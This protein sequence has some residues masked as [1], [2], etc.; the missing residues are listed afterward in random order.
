MWTSTRTSAPDKE[1]PQPQAGLS[2][3]GA[4]AAGEVLAGRFELTRRLGAGGLAEVFAA[5]DRLTGAEVAVKILH[6]H[7]ALDR[8]LAERFR[9][10]L[11]ITRGLDHPGIVRVFDLHEH[12]GRPLFSMELL[13]GR[14]LDEVLRD[15]GPMPS[16]A[17]RHLAKEICAALQAAHAAGVVHRD[18]KPQNVFVTSVGALKLLDFG[19][20]RVAGQTPLTSSMS[21]L[22]TPGYIA[23]ELLAGERADA[24]AD[25]YA[26]G[27][28]LCEMLTRRPPLASSDPYGAPSA[29]PRFDDLCAE[30]S[31]LLQRAL[32][33][34]PERRFL[35]AAQLMR[36]LSGEPVPRPL[37]AP[38][39][40]SAG[41]FDVLVHDVV[42]PLLVMRPLLLL[43]PRH[44]ASAA[45]ERAPL[46]SVLDR[47]GAE[48]STPWRLRLLGAGQA[49]L[50]SGASRRTAEATAAVCAEHGLPATVRPISLRPRSEEWLARH[51]GWALALLCVAGAAL[52]AHAL[53]L[54]AIWLLA[55][56]A[57]GYLLSWGLRPP[58][59]AAPL[60][61]LPGHAS[62]LDRLAD[63][64]VRRAERLRRER[65]LL[66]AEQDALLRA[67]TD[68]AGLARGLAAGDA[69]GGD[70]EP[71]LDRLTSRLLHLATA[72]DD[73]LAEA[74]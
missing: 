51:G 18:L 44:R 39:P 34:D 69:A 32:E 52:L 61:V 56:A 14:T 31:E 23:P 10:E 4:F 12:R 40:L 49:V 73:A 41:E 33:P 28:T 7:L 66:S 62:S 24:R 45:D 20:A 27:A 9:R 55:G 63:G 11:G 25:L 54:G 67:A 21:V 47:L 26:L 50:V 5:R 1:G 36:A 3:P 64:I 22:G 72:L 15:E 65:N 6:A 2:A 35:D 59:S 60:S 74:A 30:D 57:V 13:H 68:A 16:G 42:R 17:A 29:P 48:A 19:L 8:R 58:A 37:A 46:V 38:P 70:A 43:R 71:S 53:E